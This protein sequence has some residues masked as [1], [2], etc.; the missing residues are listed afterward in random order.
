M[1]VSA[2]LI[3]VVMSSLTLISFKVIGPFRLIADWRANFKTQLTRSE[4]NLKYEIYDHAK[5]GDSF[6]SIDFLK[7]E[8]FWH[9]QLVIWIEDLKGDFIKTLLV[10]NSTAKGNFYGGRTADNFK[11]FDQDKTLLTEDIRRV[12]ALPHWAFKRNIKAKDGFMVPHPD[13]PLHDG[14]SGATPSTNFHFYGGDSN[15]S[16]LENFVIKMEVNVAFDQNKY[17]SEYDFLED[18]QY[19]SG[20]G[21]MG[22][23]SLVYESIIDKKNLGDYYLMELVGHGHPS[24][25]NGEIS[26]DLSKITTAKKIVE[27]VL[28]KINW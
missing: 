21:L 10:T 24:G 19:H 20:T 18:D 2:I 13:K 11:D 17:F 14:I 26:E 12:N 1:R 15:L 9:P 22:Q 4:D 8:H 27:R 3:I 7:G 5:G 23:P 25:K 6:I 16:A 28:V